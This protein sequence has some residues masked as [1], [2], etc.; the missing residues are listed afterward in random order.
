[1]NK[2]QE[3]Q[4]EHINN[5]VEM[6]TTTRTLIKFKQPPLFGNIFNM[7]ALQPCLVITL[8]SHV[9]MYHQ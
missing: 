2:K 5:C 3:P 7:P 4:T 9:L 8:Q 1:M 6:Q